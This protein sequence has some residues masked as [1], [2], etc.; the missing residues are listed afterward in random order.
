MPQVKIQ[1][2]V[3]GQWKSI[4]ISQVQFQALHDLNDGL[5]PQDKILSSI[6]KLDTSTE[7]K[8]FLET[9]LN[10]TISVGDVVIMVGQKIV[11]I[12][13]SV[14]KHFPKALLGTIIGL[15][16][17]KLISKVP[18]FGW[19][20]GWILTPLAVIAGAVIGGKKDIEDKELLNEI[21][22]KIDDIFSDIKDINI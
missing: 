5:R 13:L 15:V 21:E 11:E 7:I 19:V 6:E 2:P 1:E 8:T 22:T 14:Y 10:Y 18:L 12:I 4:T 9:T 16:V 3:T 17:G 20:L